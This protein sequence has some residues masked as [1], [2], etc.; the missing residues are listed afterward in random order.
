MRRCI[1]FEKGLKIPFDIKG[2]PYIRHGVG[3]A[4]INI[5]PTGEIEYLQ[6]LSRNVD[7]YLTLYSDV[8]EY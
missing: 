4:L 1:T 2:K 7:W 6:L 3:L 5:V 8:N